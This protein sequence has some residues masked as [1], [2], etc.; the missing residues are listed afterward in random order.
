MNGEGNNKKRLLHGIEIIVGEA[1]ANAT[2]AIRRSGAEVES[3]GENFREALKDALS[4]RNSVVMVRLNKDSL[5][6][7]DELVDAG[8]V[9]SRSEAT[10]FLVADGIKVRA[11]LF[12]RISKKIDEIRKAKQDLR[13][14]LN[15]TSSEGVD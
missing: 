6:R 7:L 15:E 1:K 4:A 3:L 9:N 12:K 11:G 5:S 10:A 13:D 2:Q 14:L 8:L